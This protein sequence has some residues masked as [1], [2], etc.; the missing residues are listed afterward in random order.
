MQNGYPADAAEAAQRAQE[1]AGWSD[2]MLVAQ[3]LVHLWT[4]ES[5]LYDQECFAAVAAGLRGLPS[6]ASDSERVAVVT[7]RLEMCFG[8]FGSE[9]LDGALVR[10]PS[11]TAEEAERVIAGFPVARPGGRVTDPRTGRRARGAMTPEERR[12][13]RRR[14]VLIVAAT[15]AVMVAIAVVVVLLTAV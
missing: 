8:Y 13:R 10:Q 4:H 7:E 2:R 11:L 15:W 14:A 3:C 12:A 1:R 5:T 6:D 9:W